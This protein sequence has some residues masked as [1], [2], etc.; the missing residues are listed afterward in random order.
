[1]ESRRVSIEVDIRSGLP[2]F[3]V[4]GLADAAVREARER[5]RAALL[6][7]DFEFPA[8]RI[9]A[10]L[11]PANLPKVGPGFDLGLALG[12]LAASEQMPRDALGEWAAFGELSLGGPD[13]ALRGNSRGGRGCAVGRHRGL[14]VPV[15][16][17][18]EAAADRRRARGRGRDAARGGRGARRSRPPVVAAPSPAVP[19]SAPA[20]TL[21]MGEVVGQPHAMEAMEIAAAGGHNLLLEGP[22]GVGKT[23]LARR[24]PGILPHWR[25]RRRWR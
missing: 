13:P 3:R 18:R 1:V 6:N 24:L 17:A 22:P 15:D 2:S 10:N 11:A 20:D 8:K 16:R 12:V 9:T 5:V 19:V 23:M 25:G 21:D 4:V 7:S 14:V